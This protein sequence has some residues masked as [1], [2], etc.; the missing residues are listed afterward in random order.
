MTGQSQASGF[1][2][3]KLPNLHTRVSVVSRHSGV[4]ILSLQCR[5]G[6]EEAA[7]KI[8]AAWK[9][10]LPARLLTTYIN[11]GAKSMRWRIWIRLALVAA[12]AATATCPHAAPAAA[13][14]LSDPVADRC[15]KDAGQVRANQCMSESLAKADARMNTMYRRLA[16]RLPDAH[17][18]RASQRGWME[19][20]DLEC[21]FRSS[22]VDEGGSMYPFLQDSCKLDLTLK[23]LSELRL[24][25]NLMAEVAPD[26]K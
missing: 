26:N 16:K 15:F 24:S 3:A 13:I 4:K 11:S 22:R 17:M 12:V 25:G 21:N 9:E 20:R 6:R 19:F 2:T 14:D 8:R 1:G 23:R 18:L 7:A 5:I 10:W